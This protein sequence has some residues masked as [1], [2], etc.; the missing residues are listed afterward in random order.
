[1]HSCPVSG[2]W[3]PAYCI[4]HIAHLCGIHHVRP[5]AGKGDGGRGGAGGGG[6]GGGGGEGAGVGCGGEGSGSESTTH[7]L[8]RLPTPIRQ[9]QHDRHSA[10]A[11]AWLIQPT[12][13]AAQTA[14]ELVHRPPKFSGSW[15]VQL[16]QPRRQSPLLPIHWL[17]RF[18]V[19][20][21]GGH[22]ERDW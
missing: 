15:V 4:D 19:T 16:L 18:K 11:Q 8:T 22:G 1:M 12:H 14:P 5:L 6:G 13:S 2:L 10:H 7:S 21:Q 17:D 9:R 20:V 3:P